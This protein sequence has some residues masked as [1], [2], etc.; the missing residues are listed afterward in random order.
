MQ[1]K[2]LLFASFFNKTL[3]VTRHESSI[4][5]FIWEFF[6]WK[7]TVCV[8]KSKFGIGALTLHI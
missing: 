2:E 1:A 5:V 4:L 8:H 6:F 7:K 3:T